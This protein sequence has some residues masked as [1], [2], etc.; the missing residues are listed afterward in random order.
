[1]TVVIEAIRDG[2]VAPIF[3]E[4]TWTEFDTVLERW[5]AERRVSN[6]FAEDIRSGILDASDQVK[7]VARFSACP[8]PRDNMLFDV[9]EQSSARWLCTD[10]RRIH[11]VG[12]DDIVGIGELVRMIE[13]VR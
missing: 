13:E 3:S 4:E 8:D 9:L 5:R 1:M 2:I 11:A 7:V 10:E 6:R 12:R